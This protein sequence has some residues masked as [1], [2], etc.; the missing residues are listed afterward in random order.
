MCEG[1]RDK[2]F[3]WGR[4]DILENA[5]AYFGSAWLKQMFGCPMYLRSFEGPN[6]GVGTRE[7]LD[8]I[9]E[10]QDGRHRPQSKYRPSSPVDKVTVL[11]VRW[12]P[13]LVGHVRQWITWGKGR[14]EKNSVSLPIL[15]V[16]VNLYFALWYDN[17]YNCA[18]R[19]G[20]CFTLYLRKFNDPL[21]FPL[22]PNHVLDRIWNCTQCVFTPLAFAFTASMPINHPS[23][24]TD[25]LH[26]TE[27]Y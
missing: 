4:I 24:V 26:W 10:T 19:L 21:S 22:V 14:R 6:D 20:S 25:L 13:F 7:E 17:I 23:P 15:Q 18:F 3:E 9:D 2:A 8:A 27:G 5:P 11:F 12:A 1:S 16:F